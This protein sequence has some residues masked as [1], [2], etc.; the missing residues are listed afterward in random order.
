MN[1]RTQ[2]LV[3]GI[4]LIFLAVILQQ[5]RKQKLAALCTF[6]DFAFCEHP[7]YGMF[8]TVDYGSFQTLR[9][10]DA[11]KHAV[12]YR[13]LFFVGY[14]IFSVNCAFQ[15]FGKAETSDTGNGIIRRK[16][17]EHPK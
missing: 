14:Y 7:G 6:V 3:V 4:A 10:S 12:F 5:V 2:I 17:E 1:M 16:I 9:Y 15:K 11:G 8:P 13:N